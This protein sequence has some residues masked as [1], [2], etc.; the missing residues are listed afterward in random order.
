M[1]VAPLGLANY[2]PKPLLLCLLSESIHF[3]VWGKGGV[4]QGDKPDPPQGKDEKQGSWWRGWD[5][6][7]KTALQGPGHLLHKQKLRMSAAACLSSQP[8]LSSRMCTSCSWKTCPRGGK[9]SQQVGREE[10]RS[11]LACHSFLSA[12]PNTA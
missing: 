5:F 10:K 4:G 3:L 1:A 11:F 7:V 8:K 6:G 9:A 2:N 12:K